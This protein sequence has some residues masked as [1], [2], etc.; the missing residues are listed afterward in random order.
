MV[1]DLAGEEIMRE[2]TEPEPE[3]AES[4]WGGSTWTVVIRVI[5]TKW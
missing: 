1:G 2:S 5:L 3:P 4:K